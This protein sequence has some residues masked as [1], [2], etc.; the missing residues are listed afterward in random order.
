MVDERETRVIPLSVTQVS[1]GRARHVQLAAGRGNA[2][3]AANDDTER[4]RVRGWDAPDGEEPLNDHLAGES[5]GELPRVLVACGQRP[6]E[7]AAMHHL[8]LHLRHLASE[9]ARRLAD[10]V[11][12]TGERR[13]LAGD[14]TI[15][16]AVR[17]N[18]GARRLSEPLVPDEPDDS[19]RVGQVGVKR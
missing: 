9:R 11:Q 7:P 13:D 18:D 17:R 4:A 3:M 1:G 12:R 2:V 8:G 6:G 15:A 14:V 5:V 16:P 19:A 10:V